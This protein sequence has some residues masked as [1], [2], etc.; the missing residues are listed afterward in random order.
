MS[1]ET[2]TPSPSALLRVATYSIERLLARHWDGLVP[3]A[4]F[5]SLRHGGLHMACRQQGEPDT[6]HPTSHWQLDFTALAVWISSHVPLA[7]WCKPLLWF[8]ISQWSR[9]GAARLGCRRK[10]AAGT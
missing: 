5:P 8:G 4:G 9:Q 6:T 2:S 3:R 7:A 10:G 1:A